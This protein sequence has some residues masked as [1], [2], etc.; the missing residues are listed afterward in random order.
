MVSAVAPG[1]AFV[2]SERRAAVPLLPTGLRHRHF[3]SAAV[4]AADAAWPFHECFVVVTLAFA[5]AIVPARGMKQ[6]GR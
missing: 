2:V 1:A 6:R 5:L 3:A 4:G